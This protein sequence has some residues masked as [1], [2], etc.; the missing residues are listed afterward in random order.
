[1]GNTQSGDEDRRCCGSN[2]Q[3][4]LKSEGT[5]MMAKMGLHGNWRLL[6]NHDRYGKDDK[7]EIS[8]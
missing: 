1:M 5:Q 2:P 7:A 6:D 8:A 4:W 3:E